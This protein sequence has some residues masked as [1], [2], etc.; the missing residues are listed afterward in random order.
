MT[1]EV[2]LVAGRGCEVLCPEKYRVGM[3]VH[4]AAP[5]ASMGDWALE[6]TDRLSSAIYQQFHLRRPV[7]APAPAP[8]RIPVL[9]D[10]ANR[11]FA[12]LLAFANQC[13]GYWESGW[14]RTG[15][16]HV[17]K[18]GLKLCAGPEQV[19]LR[20]GRAE[21]YFPSVRPYRSS[22]FVMILSEGGLAATNDGPIVR[23][24]IN[25]PASLAP[26]VMRVV[27]GFLAERAAPAVFKILNNPANY[28]R[29]DT[30]VLYMQKTSWNTLGCDVVSRLGVLPLRRR[31]SAFVRRLR[32]GL[33]YAEETPPPSGKP[34]L[35]YGQDIARVIGEALVACYRANGRCPAA[36]RTASVRRALAARADFSF[37]NAHMSP[38]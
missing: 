34:V 17:E 20:D 37:L 24:Y 1:P 5:P 12:A 31:L 2:A 6:M 27:T 30:A 33:G 25:T 13:A 28:D 26:R 35:S 9:R 38:V 15:A 11:E 32:P 8:A 19:R 7:D 36:T 14:I 23:L 10:H 16:T 3:T 22:G 29:C 18:N 21:V 4:Q